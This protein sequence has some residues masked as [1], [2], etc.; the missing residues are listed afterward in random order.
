MKRI[1]VLSFFL[2]LEG[3]LSF[4][5]GILP[6]RRTA[7][8]GT[9]TSLSGLAD[10]VLALSN[11]NNPANSDIGNPGDGN[12]PGDPGSGNDPG[13]GNDSG[14]PGEAGEG[15][16]NNH[17]HG[18]LPGENGG[19]GKIFDGRNHGRGTVPGSGYGDGGRPL[20]R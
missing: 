3:S 2:I 14:N 12:D 7:E 17:G 9:G 16:G 11:S 6:Y 18:G 19:S 20:G 1:L 13:D 15:S 4:G 10:P 5:C 8:G